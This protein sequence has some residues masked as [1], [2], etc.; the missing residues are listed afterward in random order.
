MANNSKSSVNAW[1]APPPS[2]WV[3]GGGVKIFGKCL[4]GGG[5]AEIFILI[6]GCIVWGVTEF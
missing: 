5:G 6:G 1:Y 4:G 2:V 3:G